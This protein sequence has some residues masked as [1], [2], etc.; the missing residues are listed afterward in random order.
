MKKPAR[1]YMG[2]IIAVGAALLPYCIFRYVS[3]LDGIDLTNEIP[4]M[5]CLIAICA[6]CRSTPIFISSTQALDVSILATL[7]AVLMRGP[8]AAMIVYAASSL[9]S[10]GTDPDTGVHQHIYNT[11]IR[12]TA[13]NMSN[14][15]ISIWIPGL[16]V[17]ATGHVPG[18]FTMPFVIWPMFVFTALSFLINGAILLTMFALDGKVRARDAVGMLRQLIPNVIA[19]MPLGLI[20]CLAFTLPGGYWFALIMLLPLML[21]RHAWK[22]YIDSQKQYY[23]LIQAFVASVEA[24]DKY[25]EG[26]SRRVNHYAQIIAE[27]MRLKPAQIETIRVAALLHDIGKIGISDAILQKPARLTDSEYDCIKRHPQ[28]GVNI[29]AQVGLSAEITDIIKHHHE[30]YDGGGYPD[31]ID[32]SSLSLG[33]QILGVADAF[34]AMTSAR[35]YR[36]GMPVADAIAQLVEHKGTQFSPEVVDCFVK[37]AATSAVLEEIPA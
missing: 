10:V 32:G 31:H 4:Q 12:K 14:L 22:L 21:A 5:L 8:Y 7:T 3:G 13:F 37:L 2:L 26:H 1:I 6:V 18:T 23:R 25:T 33:A 16:L 27:A 24:K 19:A 15:L 20:T 11:P 28:I 35:P 17:K 9:I 30:R 34:D 29:V 36:A